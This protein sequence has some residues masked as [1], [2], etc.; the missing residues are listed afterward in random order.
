M[1]E[2]ELQTQLHQ[3]R[4][5]SAGHLAIAVR[6]QGQDWEGQRETY[7][8]AAVVFA[9]DGSLLPFAPLAADGGSV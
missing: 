3:T 9:G 8:V 5:A 7:F 4:I 2:I 1:L 6:A